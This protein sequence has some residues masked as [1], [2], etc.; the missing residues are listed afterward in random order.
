MINKLVYSHWSKPAEG[1]HVG[2]NSEAMFMASLYL[3]LRQNGKWI[4]NTELVTDKAGEELIINK[5]GI[6]FKSVVVTMDEINYID[7]HHWAIGKIEACRKQTEPF[8][9]VDNDVFWFKRIPEYILKAQACFQN[10]ETDGFTFQFYEGMAKNAGKNF[11]KAKPFVDYGK[12]AAVNCG[13][14]GFNDL[15]FIEEW[16]E[17][18]HEYINYFDNTVL[19]PDAFKLSSLIF[20]QFHLYYFLKHY[21]FDIKFVAGDD[22]LEWVTAERSNELGYTHL[23]SGSKRG[24]VVEKRLLNRLKHDYNDFYKKLKKLNEEDVTKIE[25]RQ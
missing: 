1:T 4:K 12:V 23:I 22:N 11:K 2:F 8:I 13:I 10:V 18:A 25:Q 17:H 3:S 20:E 9:H 15:S 6:P 19:E 21:K 5:Y 14:M 7:S 24:H 16:A